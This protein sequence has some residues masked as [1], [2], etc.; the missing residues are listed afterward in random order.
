MCYQKYVLSR[1]GLLGSVF[2]KVVPLNTT[3]DIFF[4]F[5]F[6]AEDGIRDK[7]VTGVQTCALPISIGCGPHGPPAGCDSSPTEEQCFRSFGSEWLGRAAPPTPS[8]NRHLRTGVGQQEQDV[9]A[10]HVGNALDG[11]ERQVSLTPLQVADVIGMEAQLV[12]E[13]FLRQPVELSVAAQVAPHYSLEVAFHEEGP[14]P[15][16][17]LLSHPLMSRKLTGAHGA[18][19]IRLRP[20]A[21]RPKP[22]ERALMNRPVDPVGTPPAPS[23]SARSD[24]RRWA[25]A[26]VPAAL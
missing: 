26:L 14:S 4:C 6:Q 12:A 7:L 25:M 9:D 19:T 23:T 16:P 10:E 22:S 13:R 5:F 21:N 24:R 18:A 20:V 17:G 3:R 15:L 8:G 2:A 1:Y 11:S